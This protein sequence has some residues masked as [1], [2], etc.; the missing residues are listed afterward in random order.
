MNDPLNPNHDLAPVAE[1]LFRGNKIEAI[2][3]YRETHGVGLKEAKDAVEQLEAGLRK[4]SPERFRA[5]ASRAGC[6]GLLALIVLGGLCWGAESKSEDNGEEA[7]EERPK[8]VKTLAEWKKELTKPQFE[9]TRLKAT[10]PAFS[11]KYWAS[12]KDGIYQCVSCG[13]PLFDS[14]TKFASGTGWPSFYQPVE[15]EAVRYEKDVSQGEVRMEVLCNCCDA[16]L[17]HVFND[18]PA[19]TGLRYCMNS[20]ALKR[21]K[22]EVKKPVKSPAKSPG[23]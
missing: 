5:P 6:F 10:E 15:K 21:V 11:G 8:V 20:V 18:G 2:K 23:E 17:G 14:K 7:T 16:H 12:K 1:A 22:R 4:Q 19:P 9:V 13:E 3:H